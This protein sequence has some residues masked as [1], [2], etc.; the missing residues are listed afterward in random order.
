[1]L[2][3]AAAHAVGQPCT[4]SHSIA[5]VDLPYRMSGTML[6]MAPMTTG[7]TLCAAARRHTAVSRF[8]LKHQTTRTHCPQRKPAQGSQTHC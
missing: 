2:Q 3:P 6:S 5:H 8:F 7:A 4:R 1:M